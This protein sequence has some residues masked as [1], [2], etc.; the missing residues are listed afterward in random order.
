MKVQG[1]AL[2]TV[3]LAAVAASPALA[4]Y[5]VTQGPTGPTY[6]GQ[7]LNFDEPGGPVGIVSPDAWLA[8]Y[9]VSIQAGDGT[10]WVDDWATITGQPWLGENNSFFGNFG[11][12]ITFD[13]DVTEFAGQFWDPSGPPSPFGGG[14][15]VYLFD[16]GNQVAVTEHTPAWGGIGDTWFDITTDGGSVFDEVRLLG[17]GF[18]PTT[19]ADNLS[20]NPVPAPGTLALL[21]LAGVLGR[22]RRRA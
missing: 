1:I 3:G 8:D 18:T 19:Y 4:G 9:G 17:F 5:T 15:Y 14:L 20:W 12:F 16:D 21:G 7:Q 22:R 2:A 10:P 11:V 13:Q 6:A